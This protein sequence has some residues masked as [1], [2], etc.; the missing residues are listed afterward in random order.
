M[1]RGHST[2]Q[3]SPSPW[4]PTLPQNPHRGHQ[5]L[6][7]SS[8]TTPVYNTTPI[9]AALTNP[10]AQQHTQC[11]V[12]PHYYHAYMQA[13]T[14]GAPGMTAEGYTLSSTYV[15]GNRTARPTLSTPVRPPQD[16]PSAQPQTV[17]QITNPLTYGSWYQPGNCRCTRQGCPF[18]GSRKAVETHMMDR[19]FIF[20]P[21]WENRSKDD[22]DTDLSLKGKPVAIQGTSLL[23]DTPE[24]IDAWIAERRKRFPTAEKVEDNKRKLEEA[25]ARGQLAPEDMGIGARKKRKQDDVFTVGTGRAFRGQG[26][27][28]RGRGHGRGRGGGD[29]VQREVPQTNKSENLALQ[30]AHTS[31]EITQQGGSDS[32]SESDNDEAPEVVSS[33]TSVVPMPTAEVSARGSGDVQAPQVLL[34]KRISKAPPPQPKR[35]PRNPFGSRPTLLRNLLLP[36][37]RI[38]ISNLSQAIRFLVDNDFLRYLELRPGEAQEKLI[39]VIGSNEAT[40]VLSVPVS[41]EVPSNQLALNPL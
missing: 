20:P 6:S 16:R 26:R 29:P 38:T 10:Y 3:P 24:A 41:T 11:N 33:K 13:H 4:H 12:S 17:R 37:I 28:G 35:P 32:E 31:S 21:G 19:H 34:P 22:W 36:E 30:A 18:A 23:L 27:Y 8:Y 39:E 5:R 7:T 2:P 25:A 40:N 9:T 14:N 1:H 15:P